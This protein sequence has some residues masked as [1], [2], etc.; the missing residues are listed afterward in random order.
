MVQCSHLISFPDD[1]KVIIFFLFRIMNFLLVFTAVSVR[2]R[3]S[4]HVHCLEWGAECAMVNYASIFEY[5]CS[6]GGSLWMCEV[7]LIPTDCT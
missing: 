6:F 3:I 7:V 5:Y 2:C 4:L 1:G